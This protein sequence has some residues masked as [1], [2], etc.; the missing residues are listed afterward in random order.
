MGQVWVVARGELCGAG[1]G[2]AGRGR[3][4]QG[5]AGQ[6]RAGQGRA[7]QG[8]AGYLNPFLLFSSQEGYIAFKTLS[9]SVPKHP[10]STGYY[11]MYLLTRVCTS[12]SAFGFCDTNRDAAYRAQWHDYKGE[13]RIYRMWSKGHGGSPAKLKLF[14]PAGKS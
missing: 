6:G 5:R 13:H 7:G 14:P 3:A 11:T 12:L 4:G 1:Q 9:G 2:R 8:R 10:P